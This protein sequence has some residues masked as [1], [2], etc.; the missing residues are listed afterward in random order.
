MPSTSPEAIV[1]QA[2]DLSREHDQA[3]ATESLVAL[4][5]SDRPALEAA[6]DQV[7]AH[8]HRQVDDFQATAT[9]TLLNRAL[10]DIPIV[11]PLDWRGRLG[12]RLH[13]P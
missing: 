12:S 4:V 3:A 8:L 6:R 2:S 10:A 7:A 13:K 9:L 1:Q 5:G 11:D